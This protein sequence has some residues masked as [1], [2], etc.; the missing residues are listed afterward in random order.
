MRWI[1]S[2]MNSREAPLFF[3]FYFDLSSYNCFNTA[4]L[5]LISSNW[6]PIELKD[7]IK[8]LESPKI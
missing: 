8:K 3:Y 6:P 1:F 4:H 7:F 5:N 2:C